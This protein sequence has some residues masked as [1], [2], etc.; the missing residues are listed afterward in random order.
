MLDLLVFYTFYFLLA[1][2]SRNMFK[3]DFH[4]IIHCCSSIVLI[5][6]F[7]YKN[8]INVITL[9]ITQQLYILNDP[10][11]MVCAANSNG[12]FIADL[13]DILLDNKNLK[14]KVYIF[15]HIVA[16]V[17]ISTVYFNNNFCI[18]AIWC[19]EIGSFVHNLRFA[20]EIYS[21]PFHKLTTILYFLVYSTTR[22]YFAI[23]IS[24]ILFTQFSFSDF[25]CL[26]VG[27]L[28][29]IQN[30]I[31]LVKNLKKMY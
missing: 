11:I 30:A 1:R 15:H 5:S 20:S 31:W 10:F 17:G 12:Y 27:I 3:I 22:I 26:L 29:T 2:W 7:F 28:L 16:I 18:F 14:R 9:N 13:I 19:L 23:N 25:I 24:H 6:Y 4:S 8:S 21:F